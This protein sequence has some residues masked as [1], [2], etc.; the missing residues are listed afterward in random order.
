MK[1]LLLVLILAGTVA[2]GASVA[3]AQIQANRYRDAAFRADSLEAALDTVRVLEL[4]ALGD[5]VNVLQL[6]A[7]Q[8]ELHADSLDE[9]LRLRPVVRIPGR[10][11]IDTLRLRDTVALQPAIGA[12][13]TEF[14]RLD[15]AQDP[16]RV[17]GGMT[18]LPVGPVGQFDVTVAMTRDVDVGVYVHCEDRAGVNAASVTLTA[19]DPFSVA[20]RAPV[21]ASREVCN[22]PPVKFSFVPEI[23]IR[24][25]GWELL[26]MA[27]GVVLW[28]KVI[29]GEDD[30]SPPSYDLPNY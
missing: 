10:L 16:F 15:L 5:S 26:K 24:G 18:R 27:L 4:A 25:I 2:I 8:T 7:I 22:R 19:D 23:S 1:K 3:Y 20:P 9:E 13:S 28:E 12:D 29:D 21:Q 17:F 11:R 30:S 14:Y 6:R